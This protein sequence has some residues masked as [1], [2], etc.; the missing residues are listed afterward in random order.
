VANELTGR[1]VRKYDPGCAP[2]FLVPDTDR[3]NISI[4]LDEAGRLFAVQDQ[5]R[6]KESVGAI[7]M[8]T[9]YEPGG[10]AISRFGYDK[11]STLIE[12]LIA[13]RNNGE[14]GIFVSTNTG[15]KRLDFPPPPSTLPLP[16]PVV[17]P[18]SLESKEIGSTK[19]TLVA[20]LNP[21]GKATQVHFEYVE[22]ATY[23]KDIAEL[24]SGHGFDH[25]T[26]TSPKSLGVEGFELEAFE[27]KLGCP[28]PAVEAS[29]P[30][31]D[32]LTPATK[33]RWR[34]L[35]TNAAGGG[36]GTLEGV[37]PFDPFETS[38]A[39]L[40]GETYATGVGTDAAKL[41]GEANPLSIPT[42]GYFEYVD[43]AH[44]QESEFDEAA[45]VPDVD[46]GQAPLEFGA[47]EGFATRSVTAFPLSSGTIY[48]YRFVATNP[49]REPAV[50]AGQPKTL[51]T[52][53]P[54]EV[55]SCSN[56]SSRIGAGAFLPDCRAY[57]MVSPVDKGGGD[58]RVLKTNQEE[59]AVLEQ[60]ADSG[61]KLAYGSVRAFGDAQSAPLT[62]QYIADKEW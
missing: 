36:E 10:A 41:S 7:R 14:G 1:G 43:D 56:G 19:A 50:I 55:D 58:I 17:V 34:V 52:F 13:P 47:G 48:H 31:N 6:K 23:L 21:E 33:Y 12:Q 32:C 18:S 49:P 53:E 27:E 29:E 35:A 2:L 45:K 16:G 42:T 15:I 11:F 61:E 9:A 51:R 46:A 54:A 62:S 22:E 4:G 38:E 5:T 59:P 20:E 37:P 40:L 3:D 44:F 60:S 57:E 8:I 28:N 30:G 39:P 26:A 24:G 25:A